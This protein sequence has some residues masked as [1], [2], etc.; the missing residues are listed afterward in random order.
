MR[1]LDKTYGP[2]QPPA[3]KLKQKESTMINLS[4]PKYLPPKTWL[5]LALKNLKVSFESRISQLPLY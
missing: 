3:K 4:E 1:T 5:H 2:V